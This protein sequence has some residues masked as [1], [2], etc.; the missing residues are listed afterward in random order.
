MD[1]IAQ[2]LT[3]KFT[4]VPT[5]T[6][7]ASA[8]KMSSSL[9]A[10]FL[11]FGFSEINIFVVILSV[12]VFAQFCFILIM[13]IVRIFYDNTR[14]LVQVY[15]KWHISFFLF[16]QSEVMLI[17]TERYMC[18]AIRN[19]KAQAQSTIGLC[20]TLSKKCRLSFSPTDSLT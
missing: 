15:K 16:S 1:L 5:F 6:R 2:L 9:I 4:E 8:M 17:V 18:A 20:S 11:G 19:D 13:I 10:T 7:S 14:P 12:C 3:Q